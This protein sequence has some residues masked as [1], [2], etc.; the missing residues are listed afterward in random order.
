MKKNA[1]QLVQDS[2]STLKNVRSTLSDAASSAEKP[3]NKNMIQRQL[4]SVDSLITECE[5][6]SSK[7]SQE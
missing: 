5:S 2:V 6:I 7:L 1:R 3:D 4:S